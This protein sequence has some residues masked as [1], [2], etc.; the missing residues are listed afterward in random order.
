[1]KKIAL[2]GA[3][4]IGGVL[5]YLISVRELGDIILIDK[6]PGL[7]KE[8]RLTSASH[9]PSTASNAKSLAQKTPLQCAT[10]TLLLFLQELQ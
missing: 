10:Q 5:A 1:M 4:N 3:G 2:V 9:L 7:A 6:K 8:K